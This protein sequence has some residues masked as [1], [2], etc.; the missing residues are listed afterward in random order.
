MKKSLGLAFVVT[1]AAATVA[2]A[3][4][5]PIFATQSAANLTGAAPDWTG[6]YVGGS[7]GST[8]SR[9]LYC[10]SFDGDEY[11]CNDPAD[12]LPEPS[13]EG[14]MIGI[15]GGYDWQSG[16]YVYGI[17]GD[18][19]FGDLSDVVGNSTDPTYGCGAGCGLEV[20]SIAILRGRLGYSMGGFLPY[21]TAGVA[22]T[23]AAVFQPGDPTFEGTYTHAVVGAGADY[24]VT[25]TLSAGIDL[26]QL[27]ETN[28]PILSEDFCGGNCGATNFSATIARVTLAYRF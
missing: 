23:Q 16:D 20:S 24:M 28:E 13:P 2:I 5:A 12:G 9:A 3:D 26:M 6:G 7:L 1:V 22:V 27:I 11:D 8:A 19:M 4:E 14:P 15:T 18:L 21:V 25:E 10:D 17:A